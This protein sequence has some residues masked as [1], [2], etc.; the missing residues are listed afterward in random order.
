MLLNV[1]SFPS[2]LGKDVHLCALL[3]LELTWSSLPAEVGN[4]T[5]RHTVKLK[6]NS[7]QSQ[8]IRQIRAHFLF[9]LGKH[10]RITL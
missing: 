1:K 10:N 6:G 4:R 9:L 2:V 3:S 8:N 7:F 5:K